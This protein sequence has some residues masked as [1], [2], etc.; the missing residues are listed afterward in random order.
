M[1]LIGDQIHTVTQSSA[2]PCGQGDVP[3]DDSAENGYGWG[4][5][6]T[7]VQKF[8]P[9]DYPFVYTDVCAAFTQD[10]GDP[11]LAFDVVIYDDDGSLR[12]PGALLGI[13]ALGALLGTWFHTRP[14]E[15]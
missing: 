14:T 15:D 13:A 2:G 6:N 10:G 8:T 5:G 7:F 4:T 9:D 1:V 11:T 3:D 12:G